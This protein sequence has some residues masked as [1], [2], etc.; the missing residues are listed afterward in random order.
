MIGSP[1]LRRSPWLVLVLV[2]A[3]FVGL[4][5]LLLP[6]SDPTMRA[7]P[8]ILLGLDAADW[9]VIDPLLAAGK[10]PTLARLKAAGRTG[11]LLSTPP[12]V[13]PI[14]W[15]TIATGR[16]P[17][18]HRVLDFMVDLPAGGQAPITSAARRVQALWNI[19]S[20]AGRRV[21]V[22]GWWATWP[23]EAVNGTIASDRVAPQLIR[24]DAAPDPRAFAP[25]SEARI[26]AAALVRASDITQEALTA[27][28]PLTAAQYE[29]ART[30]LAT[31]GARFYRD[32]FAHLAVIVASTRTHSRLAEAILAAGQPDLLLVYLE[33]IDSIS[34]LFVRDPRLGPL[35]IE[36]AYRD[37]DELLSRLAAR[38]APDTWILVCS[39][40]GFYPPDAAIAEDPADLAGPATAWH[41]P[42]GIV[43]AVEA[44]V[45][46][47]KGEA[48][49][50]AVGSVTPLDLAPTVLHAAGLPVSLE[51]PGRVVT[52]LLPDEAAARAVVKVPSLEPARRPEP[53]AAA[54]AADPDER[55]RLLALGYIGAATTSLAG[56]NLGEVLYRRG[57]YAGAERELRAVVEAQPQNVA[58]LLWLAKAV[59]EQGRTQAAFALY[60]RA[61]GLS[62]DHGD[63]LIETVDLAVSSGLKEEARRLLA[64]FRPAPR[65][66]AAVPVARAIL[67][68]SDGQ[69]DLAE[70]E[71]RAALAADPL[72]I[73]ALSRL[74]DLLS[75]G[76]HPQEAVP[77]LSRA[78]QMA[79][80]S[81]RL[82]ALLGEARLAAGDAAGAEAS[83]QHALRLAP[84]GAPIMIDLARAQLAQGRED[85][86]LTT[87]LPAP[88]SRERSILLGAAHARQRHWGE[89]AI[90]YRAALE[91]GPA[92]PELLNGLGYAQLELGQ[93]AE[94]AQ[95][96]GRSLAM[97]KNQP[98][99][100]RLL[101][102]LVRGR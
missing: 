57:N 44:R 4:P 34:H 9:L 97:D 2:A 86:A 62:A 16:R 54:A 59:R 43:A 47:G 100:S 15:T 39:D 51:M 64:G 8:I 42:Y 76:R 85:R 6:A 101:A 18:D 82:A 95:L 3:G 60:A 36:R 72:S 11:I 84:D 58:A 45:L 79:P 65:S 46:A 35:A 25:A 81:P 22:V 77:P 13:S 7:R 40:H 21:G 61:L 23:A 66:A 96:F 91:E 102:G 78:A 74:L 73:P 33:E 67:A 53:P 48:L 28:V 94:A 30:A 69:A 83:L 26:L 75:A 32:P 70:R 1:R 37:A 14:V 24:A 68:A 98:D 12:L 19:F 56:Q 87:L 88:P 5:P 49:G 41:R 63:V 10:L 71:L 38:S 89:A 52:A 31:P 90:H 17:E 93:T 99:I 27:Y 20:A 50:A 92:T 29:S 55:E 80:G